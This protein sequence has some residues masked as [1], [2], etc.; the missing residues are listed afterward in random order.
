[1][2]GVEEN[3]VREAGEADVWSG[4]KEVDAECSIWEV[5]GADVPTT[6]LGRF[7]DKIW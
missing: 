4:K 2:E 1:M 6:A 5:E 3:I 7:W